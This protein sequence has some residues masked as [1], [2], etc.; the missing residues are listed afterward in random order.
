MKYKFLTILYLSLSVLALAKTDKLFG[1]GIFSAN[2]KGKPESVKKPVKKSPASNKTISYKIL[3]TNS[4]DRAVKSEELLMIHLFGTGKLTDNKDTIIF[5]SYA[6]GNPFFIPAD[7]PTLG[8]V[9]LNL[10]KNDSLEIDV[11]ADTLFLNSFK[12]PTPPF[13]KQNS[14]IHFLVKVENVYN[15]QE[16]EVLKQ[17][18]LIKKASKDS[19][20]INALLAK[21]KDIKTTASGLKYVITKSTTGSYPQKGDEVQMNYTGMFLDGKKFDENLNTESPFSFKLGTGQVIAGWDEGILLLHE[22]EEAKLIIPSDLGYGEQGTGPIPPNTT[23][24]FDV[25][26]LKIKP[27]TK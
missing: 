17:A 4:Q 9:F 21:Y 23:L 13:L 25:K 12:Q 19:A 16:L 26:L 5:N 7:E 15:Q 24:V 3:K 22:G 1:N 6:A 18:E 11:L 20:E 2:Q 10:R 14:Y 27:N 8:K